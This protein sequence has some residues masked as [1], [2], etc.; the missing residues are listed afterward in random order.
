MDGEVAEGLGSVNVSGP[1]FMHLWAPKNTMDTELA[2]LNSSD[3][4][5][6]DKL[7]PYH[8]NNSVSFARVEEFIAHSS[9][10]I[11]SDRNQEACGGNHTI[12]LRCRIGLYKSATSMDLM[13]LRA[14]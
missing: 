14:L 2:T 12:A 5:K 1:W 4:G 13:R 7:L 3:A 10:H 11:L 9:L 8:A 6:Y